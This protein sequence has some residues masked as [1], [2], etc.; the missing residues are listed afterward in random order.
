[1]KNTIHKVAMVAMVSL[2]LSSCGLFKRTTKLDTTV[3]VKASDSTHIAVRKS[4]SS[5]TSRTIVRE[6]V[7]TTVSIPGSKNEGSKDLD[8]L[9]DGDSL[10]VDDKNQRTVVTLD[11][12]GRVHARTSVKD[13]SERV[14]IDKETIQEQAT[15]VKRES[16]DA[17]KVSKSDA[18]AEQKKETDTKTRVGPDWSMWVGLYITI[19]LF[20]LGMILFFGRKIKKLNVLGL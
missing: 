17:T 14:L 20:V 16:T 12:T 9:K 19:G 3:K 11:S 7:D 8:R 18:Q 13:R 4:D 2:A 15:D 6:K 10:V 1:M 5:A